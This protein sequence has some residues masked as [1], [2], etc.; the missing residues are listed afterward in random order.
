MQARTKAVRRAAGAMGWAAVLALAGCESFTAEDFKTLLGGVTDVAQA[1]NRYEAERRAARGSGAPSGAANPQRQAA[2][3]VAT[4]GALSCTRVAQ[5]GGSLCME[6]A[7]GRAVTLHARAGNGATG[8]FAVGAGQCAP[9]VPGTVAFACQS[10]DRF[11]WQRAACV[12][13]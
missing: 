4:Y 10:G 11:D 1:A 3:A 6:N 2:A 9:V 7:C 8:A 5:R 12:G 13:S